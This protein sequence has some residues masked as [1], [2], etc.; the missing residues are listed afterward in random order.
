MEKKK[1][2]PKEKAHIIKNTLFIL[3]C[4]LKS[5]P[6]AMISLY[7]SNII[8]NVYYSLVFSVFFLKTALSVIEGNGSFKELVIKIVLMVI[9]KI[10]V[11]MLGYF[12]N[13]YA[14]IRFEIKCE[15]YINE[16]I[17]KK[18][19]QVELGCYENPEFFDKY[20]RAT[21]VVE[22][23]GFKRIVGGTSWVIGSLISL[24]V[25]VSYL[26]SIDPVMIIFIICP[27]FVMIFRV[28]K[29]KEEFKKEKETTPYERQ[30][31]YVRRTV[32]LKDF[33]KEIKT[34]DIF[35]VLKKRFSDAIDKN[36][37]LIKKYG[38][39]VA[40]LE[41]LSDFFGDV[42]PVAGGFGYGCY[43]LVALENLAVSDF[44]V[45]VSAILQCRY[46]IN[47]FARYFTMQ[48]KH[49]LWVQSLRE[50]LAYEPK[51]VD[52]G[53]DT[54]EMETL[55]FRNVSF[56][57]PGKDEKTLENISF[58]INKGETV[59]VVGHNGAGKTTLSKLLMRLY[60][61][62]EGEILYNGKNIKEY[63]LLS[64]RDRFAS[65]FQDYRIFAMTVAEN[66]LM[67]ETDENN[68][69]LAEKALT[70]S[71]VM[72][73]IETLPEGVNTLLTKEFDDEGASLSGGETQK[74]AI[75][76]LF[77]KNFDVAVLDEPSSALDPVAESKMY[78]ALAEG[79]K[80]KTV[81]YISHRLSSAANADRILVFREGKLI[82]T[83]NHQELMEKGGEYCEMFTLQA[84]GYREEGEDDEENQ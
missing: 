50:F 74:L 81:L 45:L 20:N 83:G 4:G 67:Q 77:A 1:K 49:C 10:F 24:I 14:R 79:T 70:Q 19:Q 75:A 7:V 6:L 48:Q 33:A 82:E 78:D 11:D 35:T 3:K 16:M 34:T 39:R 31:E 25:M 27:V 62:T 17:F 58:K 44:S 12:T 55:E 13:F 63:N 57:Y 60:D 52:G 68:I 47:N 28:L 21:W 43:R 69:P 84:S 65:V 2:E 38:M 18:A 72:G 56:S 76:R 64:Y 5:A 61:V 40:V 71:G 9:G 80:D 22:K 37:K 29:N 32:L 59:A 66:V 30:K 36:I 15:A 41:I 42:I 23:H 54:D 8:E 53:I 51:I 26:M 46:K 73:K